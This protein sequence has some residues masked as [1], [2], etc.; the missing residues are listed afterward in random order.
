MNRVQRWFIAIHAG[1]VIGYAVVLIRNIFTPDLITACDFTVFWTAWTLVLNGQGMALYQEAAQRFTQQRLMDGGYFEGGLMAFLNPPHAAL[2]TSPMGWVA[3]RFGEPSAFVVWTAGNV[4]LL[5]LL[6]RTLCDECRLNSPR[7]RRIVTLA[8]LGFYPVFCTLRTGQPSIALALAAVGVFRAARQSRPVAGAG[9]LMVLSVKPQLLPVMIVYAAAQR[10][11]RMLAYAGAMLTAIVLGTALVIGPTIWIEYLTHV[12]QL[13]RFWGSGTPDYMLNLRGALL[14]MF[15]LVH[16]TWIDP[17][18]YALWMAALCGAAVFVWRRA[19]AL[20][21]S[22]PRSTFAFVLA[23]ALLT[24]PHLFVHDAVIWT[25]PLALYAAFLRDSAVDWSPFVRFALAWP[26]L[27]AIAGAHSV[28]SG[29]FMWID[30]HL[31]AF[32][33]LTA[34]IGCGWLSLKQVE[35][36]SLVAARD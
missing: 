19:A 18:V 25:V 17:L 28:K 33:A 16:A 12:R 11:W 2:A 35:D 7:D 26:V 30:P 1:L 4:V 24:N 15:G 9:W 3:N 29:R 14:R 36:A 34:M 23:L 10:C 8:V 6:I 5:W 22:D 13:E 21:P 31:W 32:V 27:F 20:T